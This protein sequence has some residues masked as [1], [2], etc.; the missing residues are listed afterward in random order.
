MGI[1]R[2]KFIR[3]NSL[4]AA[5][6]ALFSH[7]S[8]AT[9]AHTPYFP[10]KLKSDFLNPPGSA[11]PS[12]YWWW[13]NNNVNKEGITRDLE[14]FQAKGMGGV[15]LICTANGYGGGSIPNGPKLL[16]AEWRELFKHALNESHRLN[17]EVGVNLCGGWAMGGP[18]IT[19]ENSGRW[20]LQ[21]QLRVSGPQKFSGKLP[22]P[23]TR[24]GYDNA[25]AFNVPGYVNM[26]LNQADYRDTAVVAFRESPDGNSKLSNERL[27]LLAVKSNRFDSDVFIR[28]KKVMDEPLIPWM[29]LPSDHEVSVKEVIDLTDKL[30]PDGHLDWE[31]PP[32]SWTIIRTGHRMTGAR[33][34]LALPE[35]DGLEID[36]L[37]EAGVESQFKHLGKALIDEAGPLAGTTLAYFHSD[38]F[39]DGYP[40]WTSSFLE[41]F[42]KYRGYDAKSYLP[43]FSGRIVGSAEIS[44]RFLYDYRKTVA[45]CMS[46]SHYKRFAELCHEHNLEVQ[47]ESAGPSWSGTMCM[48]GLKNLGRSDRPMG[49]FWQDGAF[50]EDGQNKTCKMVSSAAHIYGRKLVSAEGF[51][52][53]NPHWSESPDILKPTADRAFCEG[54]NR[55]VIHTST[56][57]RPEDGKPGYE[58]AAGTHFNPNITWWGKSGPFLTY[59]SRCQ[60]LLQSGKFV[61]DVLY[62]NGDWAPNLVEAKHIDPALGKGY[63]YDVCNEEVLLTRLS[64]HNGRIVLPDGMSYSILVLPDRIQMPVEVVRKIKELVKAGATVVGPKPEQDPGLKNY[65]LCDEEVRETGNQVWGNCNGKSVKF[66]TYGKGRV[67]W[68]VPLRELLNNSGIVPDFEYAVKDAFIDFIHR[69]TGDTEIYFVVNRKDQKASLDCTFRVSDKVPEIWDPVTGEIRNA[70]CLGHSK[71]VT[72]LPLEFLPYQSWFIVFRRKSLFNPSGKIISNRGDFLNISPIQYIHGPWQLQFDP[73]WG[74]PGKVVFEKLEDWSRRPEEGIKFYSGTVIYK[75]HFNLEKDLPEGTRLFLDLGEVKNL[76]ELWLNGK[77]LGVVWTAPWRVEITGIVKL[78][79]DNELKIEV[80]NLWPNRLIGDAALPPEKRLT[81]TNVELKKDAPLLRSGLLGPVTIQAGAKFEHY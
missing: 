64:V 66:H 39:E 56:A 35:A 68:N 73:E 69:S 6:L 76:A 41:K 11:K 4:I 58:Y 40:N 8:N 55:I 65:P 17:L 7:N 78:T 50:V 53:F 2:R 74:G 79:D 30:K 57:S 29:S 15:L 1:D 63:D 54:I 81:H 32:G 47:N 46:D 60:H 16:S 10:D 26:P 59:I 12:C 38:S 3:I 18:W 20:Y 71:G 67:F 61:A 9:F 48:D 80:V 19:P 14:E 52:S 13:F 51:T 49:E 44:D 42:I 21:S 62:Y 70:A 25:H 72:T 27:K 31:V 75:K 33:T 77:R 22:L 43:V 34:V 36:W 28:A 5:N 24:D 23:G 45:D 37:S